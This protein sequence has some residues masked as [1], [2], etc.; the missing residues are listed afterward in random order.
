MNKN[1]NKNTKKIV[2]GASGKGF[3]VLGQPSP[4]LKKAGW[5]RRRIKQ[6]IMDLIARLDLMSLDDLNKLRIDIEKNPDKHSVREARLVRYMTREK[7]LIDYLDRNVG[8][9]QQD[10]DVTSDGKGIQ[11]YIFEI[12]NKKGGKNGQGE[13]ENGGLENSELENNELNKENE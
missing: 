12:V 4:E 6:E 10:I 5:E 8:R 2:G 9:P 3:D 11:K 1:T 13:L 7:F